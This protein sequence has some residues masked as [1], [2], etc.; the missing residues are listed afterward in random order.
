MTG[1]FGGVPTSAEGVTREAL[2]A[3]LS[4]AHAAAQPHA[5]NSAACSATPLIR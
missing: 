2:P 5:W 3:A 1:P 4:S